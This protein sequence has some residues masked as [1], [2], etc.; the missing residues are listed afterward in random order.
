[1]NVCVQKAKLKNLSSD[2]LFPLK[3]KKEKRLQHFEN[4]KEQTHNDCFS[5]LILLLC[6]KRKMSGKGKHIRIKLYTISRLE[7]RVSEKNEELR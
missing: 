5:S 2:S 3:Y 1:M 4:M 7:S 6:L